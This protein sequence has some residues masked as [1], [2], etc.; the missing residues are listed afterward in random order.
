MHTLQS[1]FT[2]GVCTACMSKDPQ[3]RPLIVLTLPQARQIWLA[4]SR[5]DILVAFFPPL[6]TSVTAIPS[7]HRPGTFL[8]TLFFLRCRLAPHDRSAVV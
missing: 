5:L 4:A 2:P 7:S 1:P 6:N 3:L 8:A